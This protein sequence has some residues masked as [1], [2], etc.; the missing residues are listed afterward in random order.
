MLFKMH[1][2]CTSKVSGP[3]PA[4]YCIIKANLNVHLIVFCFLL[5]V[6]L[7]FASVNICMLRLCK[8]VKKTETQTD[9]RKIWNPSQILCFL[10][11]MLISS[12]DY[13]NEWV[14]LSTKNVVCTSKVSCLG[15]AI[16][17]IVTSL[18]VHSSIVSVFL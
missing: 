15:F 9:L 16:Y 4:I 5:Y 11:F 10:V 1:V 2:V 17:C 12:N 8:Y 6:V 14:L 3:R 13:I 18:H 7:P